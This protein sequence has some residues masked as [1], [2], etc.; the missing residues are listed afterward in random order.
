MRPA[1]TRGGFG[2]QEHT[3]S[4]RMRRGMAMVRALSHHRRVFDVL[5][6]LDSKQRR[7]FLLVV[8]RQA[9]E[10]REVSLSDFCGIVSILPALQ[11][12]HT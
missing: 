11:R 4:L 6:A 9:F 5:R 1:V 2:L 10:S 7:K 12:L 3:M 8:L